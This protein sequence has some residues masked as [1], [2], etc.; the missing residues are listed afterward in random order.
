LQ[1]AAAAITDLPITKLALLLRRLRRHL[2]TA[3]EEEDA[4]I[5]PRVIPADTKADD[6]A[7]GRPAAETVTESLLAQFAKVAIGIW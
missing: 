4:T 7:E 2:L 6:T 5:T 3:G 1:E